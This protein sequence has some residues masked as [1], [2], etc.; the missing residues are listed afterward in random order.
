MTEYLA[1]HWILSI[2]VTILLGAIGSGLW[3][4]A[5]KP[6]TLKLG[7]QL[8]TVITFGARRSRDKIYKR[9]AM[10]HHELPSLYILLIVMVL[11]ISALTAT[12][13]RLY[14]Q[15]Y[16][17]E[18]LTIRLV[19]ECPKEDATKFKECILTLP[20]KNVLLS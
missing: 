1:E 13:M 17:P 15:L 4:A 16:A 7:S 11:G 8:Y 6:I 5:L 9:A 18:I 2:V 12:Q 14:V 3:D 20:P 19:A 10:G